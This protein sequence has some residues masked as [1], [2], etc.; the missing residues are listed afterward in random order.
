MVGGEWFVVR[1][2]GGEIDLVW[3]VLEKGKKTYE[4]ENERQVCLV[5]A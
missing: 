1:E 4:G 3:F 2:K 5:L